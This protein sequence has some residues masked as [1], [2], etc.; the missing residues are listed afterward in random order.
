MKSELPYSEEICMNIIWRRM[1]FLE[2]DTTLVDVITEAEAKFNVKWKNQ[3]VYTLLSRLEEKGYIT[4]HKERNRMHYLPVEDV[5]EYRKKKLATL[6]HTFYFNDKDSL[7][8]DV[9]ELR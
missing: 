3:T 9:T 4:S 5:A 7:K 6:F 8:K 2:K 1:R